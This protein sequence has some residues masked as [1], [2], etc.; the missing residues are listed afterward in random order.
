[1]NFLIGQK[2]SHYTIPE[3]LG[4]ARPHDTPGGYR[5]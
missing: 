1:M 3:H 5:S 4:G 2:A